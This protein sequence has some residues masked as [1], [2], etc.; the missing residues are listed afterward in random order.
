[1]TELRGRAILTIA[2]YEAHIF[3]RIQGDGNLGKLRATLRGHGFGLSDREKTS[4]QGERKL[5]ATRTGPDRLVLE[6]Q[7]RDAAFTV[8][9]LGFNVYRIRLEEGLVDEV[10]KSAY[11][12]QSRA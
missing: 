9:M 10:W 12:R 4:Q 11:V 2:R 7:M 6:S 1:M 8:R 5:I 3:I